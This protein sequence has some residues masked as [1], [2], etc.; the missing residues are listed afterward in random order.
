MIAS[1]QL[2][3]SLIEQTRQLLNQAEQLKTYDVSI[4]TWKE[5]ATTWN[6]L[7]CIEHLNRYGDFYL[8]LIDKKIQQ[9]DSRPDHN[10]NSGFLG[11]YFAQSMLPKNE[12]NKMKT[13]KDKDPLNAHVNKT[14][15]DKF[16]QQKILLLDLL[17]RSRKVS[18]NKIR[19]PT[20][21]SNL[22]RLKLGDTFLFFLNHEIRHFKQIE[23]IQ[24]A[25]KKI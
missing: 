13:F 11:N 12:L 24:A 18:L 17:H 10:F 22:L 6:I 4:L 20:S 19:I 7:E 14:V 16:I 23:R 1:E 5:N 25:M 9:S 8:P 15:I 3:Q 2:I 21:I